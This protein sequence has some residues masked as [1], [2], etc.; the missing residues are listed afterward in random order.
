MRGTFSRPDKSRLWQLLHRYWD[1]RRRFDAANNI[2]EKVATM[3]TKGSR[4]GSPDHPDPKRFSQD[5]FLR[6]ALA[7]LWISR[8]D[9]PQLCL[10]SFR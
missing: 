4:W 10:I 2:G 1:A 9:L 3:R 8:C 5:L 7:S 6:G